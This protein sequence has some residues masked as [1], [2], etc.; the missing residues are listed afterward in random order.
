MKSSVHH[1]T[2][3]SQTARTFAEIASL[4]ESEES[5]D[6]RVRRVLD[7]CHHLVPYESCALLLGPSN[8]PTLF[9]IPEAATAMRADLQ[10]SLLDVLR[11]VEG[12]SD[13]EPSAIG[14]SHLVLPLI[15]ADRIVG[16]L[17]VE[18]QDTYELHHVQ[19]LSAVA[20]QLG[21]YLVMAEL[22]NR[23]RRAQE[24]LRIQ[25]AQFEVLLNQAPLGV[26]LVDAD[27]RIR[28]MNPTALLVFGDIPS[29]IGR[30]FDE[31]IHILW[32]KDY[33]DEIVE[34]F[35]HTL[36]TGEPYVVPERIEE[37]RDRGVREYYEW[38][39]DRI[40]L[41]EGRY[42]V[43]CYFRDI[44]AQVLAREAIAES[45]SRFRLLA[46]TM[47]QLAWMA[48]PTGWIFWYN[49]RWYE[50]TGA[51]P[52]QMEG[53]GWESVHD[54]EELPKVLERWR[55]SIFTGR[56]FEMV[57]PLRGSDGVFRPFLTRVTPLYDPYG[58]VVRWFG[59][60]TILRST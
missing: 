50:Y 40:P 52:E 4:L 54:P 36:E 1:Q 58:K 37:R 49:Q 45:E 14:S 10:S 21:T 7:S 35:R 5:R 26:Y 57:F 18:R 30:D 2:D 3:S 53:W 17:R 43:V 32:S 25:T 33:A 23:E 31:V 59:T 9:T 28:Q 8:D 27:F 51:T 56:Q 29:L 11:V 24:V 48:D 22:K 39:I 34:R 19:L 6:E 16:V 44:S 12:D 47:P 42:G 41:S 46:N 13:I 38:R 20:S 55:E 15:G 60:N